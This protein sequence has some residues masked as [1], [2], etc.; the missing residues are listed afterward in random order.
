MARDVRALLCAVA[1]RLFCPGTVLP[2]ESHALRPEQMRW[3]VRAF[4]GGCDEA[5][6]PPSLRVSTRR[7]IH[8]LAAR[9]RETPTG[10]EVFELAKRAHP[11]DKA[12]ALGPQNM[13]IY[14]HAHT[15]RRLREFQ[16][17]TERVAPEAM[18]QLGERLLRYRK[19]IKRWGI[20]TWFSDSLIEE[21]MRRNMSFCDESAETRPPHGWMLHRPS[22][23][24]AILAGVD[25]ELRKDPKNATWLAAKAVLR[26]WNGGL[27]P[28]Y[29]EWDARDEYAPVDDV[30]NEA[31]QL[32]LA[33][34]HADETNPM[35]WCQYGKL[36]EAFRGDLDAAEEQYKRALQLD[37]NHIPTLSFY[38]YFL[39]DLRN[40][41]A[42][43]RKVQGRKDLLM[44]PSRVHERNSE[45]YFDPAFIDGDLRPLFGAV[46]RGTCEIGSTEI[47][48]TTPW[49]Y[50]S[51]PSPSETELRR[52]GYS[53]DEARFVW[54]CDF[55][56][57]DII[58]V[59]CM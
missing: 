51:V 56:N 39:R 34:L 7:A 30:V 55:W 41:T 57:L 44:D 16:D 38:S 35:V 8:L 33:S 21:T 3:G 54:I 27:R 46:A 12:L 1:V 52:L 29:D 19:R 59:V 40:D 25:E 43:W 10:E 42:T 14:G 6:D 48:S 11:H 20:P 22:E 5:W 26:L 50:L 17:Y 53:R 18:M 37:P 13:S 36:L 45:M 23:E 32:F 49:E 2:A 15:I 31:E 4:R 47:G 9:A 28:L 24:R 58:C